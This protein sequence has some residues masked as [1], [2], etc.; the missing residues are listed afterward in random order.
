MSTKASHPPMDERHLVT[1]ITDGDTGLLNGAYFRLRLDEEFKKSWRFQWG[2]SL[3]LVEVDGL[4]AIEKA[5]GRNAADATV[6]DIAGEILTASR[7]VDL[8]AR[9]ARQRF[10]MLLPGTGTDGAVTMVRRVMQAVL[11]KVED[12]V[13]LAVGISTCPQD[14]LASPD[15]FLARAEQA[16]HMARS[17][18]ANQVV[19]WNA[20]AR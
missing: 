7:D 2:Y 15:E 20:P 10:A 5:E 9:L 19:T 4:A 6:L 12:R 14:K 3:L 11:E 13:S 8:S 18:G 1:L 17:Q 16:L